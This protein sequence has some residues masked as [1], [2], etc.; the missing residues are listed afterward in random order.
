MLNISQF[1][2]KIQNKQAQENL[3]RSVVCDAIKTYARFEV[4]V[5]KIGFNSDAATIEGLT[6]T[7]KT[8]IYIKKQAILA[9]VN[10]AQSVRI[11]RDIR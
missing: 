5:D 2:K 11:I 1:F 7:Q 8:Q 10:N 9:H 3:V 6:A 4:D